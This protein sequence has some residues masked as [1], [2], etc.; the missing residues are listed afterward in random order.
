M[1]P[2]RVREENR[3]KKRWTKKVVE[4]KEADEVS[5]LT[6]GKKIR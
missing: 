5:H 1:L 6:E 3:Y 4:I 2:Q